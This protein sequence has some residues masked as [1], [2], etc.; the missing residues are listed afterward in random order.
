MTTPIVSTESLAGIY[1]RYCSL[2]LV[3]FNLYS[4]YRSQYMPI[5]NI[6]IC[7]VNA[8]LFLMK[9]VILSFLEGKKYLIHTQLKI[10]LYILLKY[11]IWYC[12]R[13]WL[14]CF[15]Y[16]I[17]IFVFQMEYF[18]VILNYWLYSIQSNKIIFFHYNYIYA[19][20]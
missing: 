11:Y 10:I 13:T 14:L 19:I 20:Q 2:L 12:N 18:F 16:L 15:K 7:V 5:H 6:I 9:Y 4:S 8:E 1:I 3:I 17:E